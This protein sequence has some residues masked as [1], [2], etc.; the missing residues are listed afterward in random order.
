M[1]SHLKGVSASVLRIIGAFAFS[2]HIA[3]V[4]LPAPLVAQ[5][6][7]I[8]LLDGKTGRPLSDRNVTLE[9][10]PSY[11]PW[12]GSVVH[13]GKDGIGTVRI[14]TDSE[15]FIMRGGPKTGKEPYRIPF[16]NCNASTSQM[17]QV[18]EVLK[19]G[20]VPGSTCSKKTAVPRPEEI[21]FWAMPKPWWQ[22]DMQ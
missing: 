16:I 12:E 10:S 13:L 8:R 2:L 14:P 17:I 7:T 11:N 4:G 1:N 22:P 21:V 9:W 19:R 5:T 15:S 20:Y 18:S 3:V 6:I